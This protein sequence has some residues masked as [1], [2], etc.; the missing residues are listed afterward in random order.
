MPIRKAGVMG[1]DVPSG[2]YPDLAIKYSRPPETPGTIPEGLQR[3]KEF[4]TQKSPL[5]SIMNTLPALMASQ[6]RGKSPE[7]RAFLKAKTDAILAKPSS[8]EEK[9]LVKLIV[10]S[11]AKSTELAKGV[12]LGTISED[13]VKEERSIED[14]MRER[15]FTIHGS[16]IG[17]VETEATRGI[18]KRVGDYLRSKDPELYNQ[19][20][21]TQGSQTESP[22][23]KSTPNEKELEVYN[24]AK[25][26]GP[27]A[28]GAQEAI[29]LFESQYGV[30]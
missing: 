11:V 23:Q 28:P 12:L 4:A 20:K 3:G 29:N 16:R 10:A 8:D 15:L 27:D 17:K 6:K 26:A 9:S 13:K 21:A 18:L 19:W 7:E 5:D 24:R 2:I 22:T 30:R 14:A 25:A 1:V